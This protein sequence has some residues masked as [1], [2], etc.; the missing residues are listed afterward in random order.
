[1]PNIG[2]QRQENTTAKLINFEPQVEFSGTGKLWPLG[3]C[4]AVHQ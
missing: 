4:F 1:M 2:L 3:P